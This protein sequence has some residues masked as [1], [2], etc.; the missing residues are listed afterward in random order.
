[1][2]TVLDSLQLQ[3]R[4]NRAGVRRTWLYGMKPFSGPRQ[5][6]S[7]L[8]MSKGKQL[9]SVRIHTA[10]NAQMKHHMCQEQRSQRGAL[11]W[12]WMSD[13]S[14]CLATGKNAW[15]KSMNIITFATTVVVILVI[16]MSQKTI[17]LNNFYFLNWKCEL[18]LIGYYFP[19]ITQCY[20]LFMI[21]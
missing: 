7:V 8:R 18:G 4:W 3:N 6:N 9:W 20:S 11:R 13:P 12:R 10:R 17:I 15:E 2:T 16:V 19:I 14:S 1:M 5:A 21:T